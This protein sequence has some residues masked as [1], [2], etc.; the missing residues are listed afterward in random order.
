MFSVGELSVDCTITKFQ[1]N[2]SFFGVLIA[3]HNGKGIVSFFSLLFWG[4]WDVVDEKMTYV[5]V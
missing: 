1:K 3:P 4:V 2:I 5:E